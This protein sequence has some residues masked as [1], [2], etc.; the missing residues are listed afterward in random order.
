LKR[1]LAEVAGKSRNVPLDHPLLRTL[2][3]TGISTGTAAR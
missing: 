2:W 3:D 1:P